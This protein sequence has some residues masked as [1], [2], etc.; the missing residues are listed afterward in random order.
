MGNR[1]TGADPRSSAPRVP[2]HAASQALPERPQ[3]LAALTGILSRQARRWAWQGPADA[4]DRWLT[5][6]GSK[7]LDLWYDPAAMADPAAV[8]C[9]AF[10][11]ARVAE[12]DDPRRLRHVSLSI[13]T[14]AGPAVIDLTR[15]DLRVGPVL[16]APVDEIEI[17]TASHRLTGAA[18][19][20]DLLVR[21]ILRGRLPGAVRLAEART[22]WD[23]TDCASRDRLHRR[24]ARELGAAVA[25][26]VVA[27]AAGGCPD[28]GLPRRAR[29]R[30]IACSLRPANAAATWAQRHTVRPAGRSAGPLGLRTRGIVVALVGTDG[31][32][33][34]TVAEELHQRLHRYGLPTSAAYFGMARGNLPGVGLAR[35]LLR[36]GDAAP[37][38]DVHAHVRPAPDAPPHRAAGRTPAASAPDGPAALDHPALRRAAAWFYAGEYGWRYLRM[39]GQP[40]WR[41]QVVIADRWIYDLRE[42]PWPGSRAAW[43]AERILPAP[44]V[45]VLPDAPIEL[46][47]RRKPERRL[48]DQRTQQERFRRLLAEHPARHAEVVVDTSGEEADP[49]AALVAVVVQA[50]HGR[51]GHAR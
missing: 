15:G 23:R 9:E 37:S 29:L 38:P 17:C 31:A 25:G 39:V 16:L 1:Q 2:S 33:K 41:R 26:A 4:A 46:I 5:D 12:A 44:D 22:A 32:G 3:I 36:V 27:V 13:E 11:C 42:S 20:A 10:A 48:T 45:L 28:R 7:D 8:L 6:T 34:S 30:F 35:R 19:V 40:R 51:R 14:A 43:F 49:L 24:L 47:H 50:A 21:P 18:A